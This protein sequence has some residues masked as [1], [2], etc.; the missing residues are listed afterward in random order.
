[1]IFTIGLIIFSLVG[2]IAIWTSSEIN[3]TKDEE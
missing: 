3:K 2:W 1:M